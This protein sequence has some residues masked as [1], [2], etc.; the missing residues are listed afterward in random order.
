MKEQLLGL[1]ES[2][3]E[4]VLTEVAKKSKQMF[5]A[6]IDQGFNRDQAFELIVALT[7]KK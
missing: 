7:G 6:Y 1:L 5:D 2:L 3:D 4:D